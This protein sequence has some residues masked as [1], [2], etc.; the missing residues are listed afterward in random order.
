MEEM[1]NRGTGVAVP[2]LNSTA[3][4]ELPILLPPETV[5][6]SYTN[7]ASQIVRHILTNCNQ[8][9]TLTA[10]R[11]ALL[12]KLISGELHLSGFKPER[13]AIA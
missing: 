3:V 1:R 11:D 12:P 8:S 2:G 5:L 6:K 10:I 7:R 13:E 4:R 9:R